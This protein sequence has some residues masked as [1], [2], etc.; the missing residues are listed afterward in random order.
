M[1]KGFLPLKTIRG[2]SPFFFSYS[3]NFTIKASTYVAVREHKWW[4]ITAG[5]SHNKVQPYGD[6]LENTPFSVVT[7]FPP[8]PANQFFLDPAHCRG[9]ALEPVSYRPSLPVSYQRG[10]AVAGVSSHVTVL[11]NSGVSRQTRFVSSV[12]VHHYCTLGRRGSFAVCINIP[13]S[14]G[15][16]PDTMPTSRLY[17]HASRAMNTE[18]VNNLIDYE[19]HYSGA[20]YFWELDTL[21]P[22]KS[23]MSWEIVKMLTCRA[24]SPFYCSLS[25]SSQTRISILQSSSS[26]DSLILSD[27]ARFLNVMMR[28]MTNPS[29]LNFSIWCMAST[30]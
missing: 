14:L 29:L 18:E 22:K 30:Q 7:R 3:C 8:R 10:R 11:F 21:E 25:C 20:S 26:M 13:L 19:S 15:Q 4:T 9:D 1:V 12:L 16:L 27:S 28:S 6:D 17:S 5:K 24:S 2:T 23:D